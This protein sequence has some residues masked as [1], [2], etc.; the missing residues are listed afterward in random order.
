MFV[1]ASVGTGVFTEE[2]P[3]ALRGFLSPTVVAFGGVLFCGLIG[4]APVERSGA[5]R[6]CSAGS[7]C[8]GSAIPR[9]SGR[10]WPR[11]V[12]RQFDLE[13]RL[14]YLAAP[15]SPTSC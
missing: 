9:G 5:T 8:S 1:A 6:C 3:V 10:T 11:R 13:D 15:P 7:A 2:R 12:R 4:I 14:W